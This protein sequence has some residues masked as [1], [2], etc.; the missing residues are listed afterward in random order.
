MRTSTRETNA[1]A[2]IL[3]NSGGSGICTR[4]PIQEI[5]CPGIRR[6]H[7]LDQGWY[8]WVERC[9][10]RPDDNAT[11]PAMPMLS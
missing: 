7:M 3:F 2:S 4:L 8:G 5:R 9:S 11:G 1:A 6:T 10:Q